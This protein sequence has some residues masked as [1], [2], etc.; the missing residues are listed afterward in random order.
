MLNLVLKIITATY[1]V[2]VFQLVFVIVPNKQ[3]KS[4]VWRYFV[5]WRL[6]GSDNQN[7]GHRLSLV[8]GL[9]EGQQEIMDRVSHRVVIR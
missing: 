8:P 9:F 4:R 7:E 2:C 5:S 6:L 3:A 1:V